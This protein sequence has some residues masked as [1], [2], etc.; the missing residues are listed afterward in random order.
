MR[1]ATH[2]RFISL[3]HEER[4]LFA[5]RLAMTLRAGLP[6]T[7]G[8][9]MLC[10]STRSRGGSHIFRQVLSDV[11]AGRPLSD[12]LRRFGP[13]FG[14]YAIAVVQVGERAGSL[15]Q[16]LEHLAEELRRRYALRR[17]ISG[18]LAYPALVLVASCAIVIMLTAVVFPKIMPV[19][20]GV[21]TALPLPTRVL[22]AVS[23]FLVR[24]HI[25]VLVGVVA[26]S[27]LAA[28]SLRLER[29]RRVA[30]LLVLRM[31]LFGPLVR[32]YHLATVSRTLSV[33]LHNDVP[34]VEALT[35]TASA[36]GNSAYRMMLH[37]ACTD[38]MRGEM[39]SRQLASAPHLFPV[40]C[41]QMVEAGERTGGLSV[42]MAYLA[43]SYE[44]EFDDRVRT[45]T[46]LLEPVLML[47]VGAIVGFIAL[48]II[49]PIYALTQGLSLR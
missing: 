30:D 29:V 24:W 20:A 3:R 11:S 22:M 42:A 17:R 16:S 9:A 21:H 8:L 18:A 23:G 7:Q 12:G 37:G 40:V 6:I 2:A 26:C 13:Q 31:P 4:L 34:I 38:V 1:P 27:V 41:V 10:D 25:Y 33:L 45:I 43:E 28:F 19:F 46:T 48:A 49:L 47:I 39:L 5:K 36:T 44:E 32:A 15:A 35:L 14:S